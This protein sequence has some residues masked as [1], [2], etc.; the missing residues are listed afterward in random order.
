M[1]SKGTIYKYKQDDCPGADLTALW[2]H[3]REIQPNNMIHVQPYLTTDGMLMI[4]FL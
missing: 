2:D 4:S 1:A 3:A